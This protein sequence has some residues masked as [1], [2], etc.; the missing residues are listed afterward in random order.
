M[1]KFKTRSPLSLYI[2]P[3]RY[4]VIYIFTFKHSNHTLFTVL[5]MGTVYN[6]S[7]L[8]C[9]SFLKLLICV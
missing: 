5:F 6:K 4:T 3:D 9:S 1:W 8:I 7:N 2:D